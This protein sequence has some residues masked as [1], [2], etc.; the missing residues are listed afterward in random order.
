MEQ[1]NLKMGLIPFWNNDVDESDKKNRL[2]MFYAKIYPI[3]A[4]IVSRKMEIEVNDETRDKS[5]DFID[6]EVLHLCDIAIHESMHRP[7]RDTATRTQKNQRKEEVV[8]A[9][10]EVYSE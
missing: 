8:Y 2:E 6:R 10:R 4:S 3:W 1:I 5:K 9:A 7:D